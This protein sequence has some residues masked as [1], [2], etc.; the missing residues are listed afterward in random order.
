MEVVHVYTVAVG[1]YYGLS[2]WSSVTR[3]KA[4]T[5]AKDAIEFYNSIGGEQITDIVGIREQK[6]IHRLPIGGHEIIT[7][8]RL[9]VHLIE[10]EVE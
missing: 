3:V 10:E 2:D 6:K 1:E 7:D 9:D 5:D 4:Y 8:V